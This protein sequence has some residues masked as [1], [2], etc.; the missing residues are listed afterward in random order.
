MAKEL[1]YFKFEPNQWQNGNIQM[2]SEITQLYFINMCCVYWSK[3][4]NLNDR[5]ALIKCFNNNKQL[6]DELIE[7]EIIHIS[8][9]GDIS[10]SFLDAQLSEF[11][12]KSKTSAESGRKGGQNNGVRP[13]IERKIGNQLYLLECWNNEERFYKLGITSSSISKRYSGKIQYQYKVVF[14]IFT[15]DFV[16]AEKEIC[17]LLK[18]CEYKPLLNFAGQKECF[19]YSKNQLI[20]HT[21]NSYFNFAKATLIRNDA[22]RE[23][24]IRE[25]EIREEEI[26]KK[27][28]FDFKKSMFNYGFDENLIDDWL[29]VRKT[30]KA[31]NTETAYKKFINQVEKS[32]H[33]INDVLEKCIEKSWS[34]FE[35]DWYKK[36]VVK[37]NKSKMVY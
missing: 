4:G 26:I 8:N 17:E 7:N 15:D 36:D 1:P 37:D 10:I 32:G 21:L 9:N 18:D 31:T 14:Q 24:E 28:K 16:K 22:I 27:E 5:F 20:E 25:N 13:E 6:F 3:L 30:K 33:S 34:G 23:E 2:C 12:I 19:L 35:A 11:K 29:K